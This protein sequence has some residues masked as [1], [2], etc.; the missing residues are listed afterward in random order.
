MKTVK[1][2][3]VNILLCL[4]AYTFSLLGTDKLYVAHFCVSIYISVKLTKKCTMFLFYIY[5]INVNP[6]ENGNINC[7]NMLGGKV[8]IEVK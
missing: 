6:L 3:G 1:H 8:K 5:L 7:Q 2:Y 4:L